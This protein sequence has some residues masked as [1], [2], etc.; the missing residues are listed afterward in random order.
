MANDPSERSRKRATYMTDDI[1]AIAR[2]EKKTASDLINGID[3]PEVEF[4][5]WKM[6]H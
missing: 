6:K 1:K 5:K 3:S 2:A 4:K